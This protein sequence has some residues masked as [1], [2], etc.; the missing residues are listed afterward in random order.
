MAMDSFD[1]L[2]SNNKAKHPPG[3]YLLFFTEMWERFSFYGMRAMLVLYLTAQYISGGLGYSESAAISIYGFFVGACYFTP[4]LGGYLS[5]RYLGRRRSITIGGLCIALGNLSLFAVQNDL[6]MAIGLALI[7]IGNGFFKPNVSTLVG[8]LY[9]KHDKRVDSAYTIFYMGI[10]IGSFL[11]PLVCGFLAE[12]WFKVDMVDFIIYGYK[13]GFLAAGIGMIIGQLLYNVL[14]PRYLGDIGKAPVNHKAKHSGSSVKEKVPMT[15]KEK[16]QTAVILIITCFVIFF[17]AGFEQAGSLLTLYTQQFIDKSI[18]GFEIPVSW[19]Q[20]VNPLFIILFAPVIS[21]L[22][23]TLSKR[24]RGDL[25]FATKMGLGMVLLGAGYMVLLIAVN[26]TGSDPAQATRQAS[27]LFILGTYFFHTIGELFLS[28]VGLALVNK[29]SPAKLT[30]LL[31]G[32]WLASTGVANI[33]GGQFASKIN[34]LGYFNTFA[35]IG[36]LSILLGLI[37]LLLSKKLTNMAAIEA[38]TF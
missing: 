17:W 31:M 35:V 27:I 33:I 26:Q 28:P 30:S 24:K 15:G 18:F 3:L 34:A 4:L 20:S 2:G 37:L 8:D 11:A 10:N 23:M 6:F 29:I 25:S 38:D 7:I 19:F 14:G 13:Y 1:H 12:Q 21:Y 9:P 16:R 22:W 5:D 36:A 32:V